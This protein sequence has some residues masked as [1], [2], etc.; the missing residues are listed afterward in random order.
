MAKLILTRGLSGSG[1]T[2]FAKNWLSHD[3][4]NRVRIN[5]DDLRESLFNQ[6]GVLSQSKEA[7]ITSVQRSVAKKALE[8]GKDVICDDTNLVR[9]FAVEWANFAKEL[10]ADFEVIDIKTPLEEC[11]ERNMARFARGGRLVPENAIRRQAQKFPFKNWEPIVA[12]EDVSTFEVEPYQRVNG[13]PAYIVDIDGTVA[14]FN[15]RGPFD[16]D[17]VGTDKAR[18]DVIRVVQKL[19]E[20]ADIIFLSG[21]D[22]SCMDDT[23]DWL[24]DN[25]GLNYIDLHMR[26]TGD[27]RPD[28]KVKYDLFNE[29]CRHRNIVGAIDDRKQVT[30]LWRKLGLTVFDVGDGTVF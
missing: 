4:E 5:R 28:Y 23:Y 12:K 29:H 19:S 11:L 17:K 13:V 3:S 25:T 1:K 8:Q 16:F 10:G 22:D 20:D 30:D 24:C 7:L 6:Q 2:T 9:K 26:K 18:Q 21:R 15:N 27:K 14:Q